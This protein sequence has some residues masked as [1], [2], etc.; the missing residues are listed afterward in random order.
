VESK[1]LYIRR[2]R[3]PFGPLVIGEADSQG[4]LRGD[5][6][7]DM[8]RGFKEVIEWFEE[9]KEWITTSGQQAESKS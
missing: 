7:W 8:V 9:R 6:S 3:Y 4:H 2:I 5:R 1:K